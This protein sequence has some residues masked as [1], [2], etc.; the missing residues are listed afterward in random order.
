MRAAT[1]TRPS[2]DPDPNPLTLGT[3]LMRACSRGHEGAASLLLDAHADAAA[4]DQDDGQTALHAAAEAAAASRRRLSAHTSPVLATRRAVDRRGTEASSLCWCD[5]APT[6]PPP[7]AE[8]SRDQPRSAERRREEAEG[9]REE[10]ER[11][12]RG[13]REEPLPPPGRTPPR[14]EELL[15]DEATLPYPTVPEPTLASPTVP[16]A[17]LPYPP[18]PEPTSGSVTSHLV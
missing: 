3:A 18:V 1:S 5:V 11:R 6:H 14:S 15:R 12:P 16:E 4:T 2:P 7:T 13:G 8:R 17:T 9:S 10:A